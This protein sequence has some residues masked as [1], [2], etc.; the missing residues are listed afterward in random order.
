MHLSQ[1]LLLIEDEPLVALALQDALEDAGY[2]VIR[3]DDGHSGAE[4]L[5]SCIGVV[6]GLITD[7]RLGSGPDGW[8]LAQRARERRPELPVLYVT[9]DSAHDWSV[10]GVAGSAV[11]Q[12]PF[13]SARVLA[14]LQ[15]M[16]G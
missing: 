10:R 5:E 13:Q 4:A 1:T 14:E 2:N 12:K 7:I 8:R 9:G 11:L 6:A 16:M 15:Q 3:A